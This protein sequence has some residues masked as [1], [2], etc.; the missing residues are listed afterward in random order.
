MGLHQQVII[1]A[2]SYGGIYRASELRVGM[3]DHIVDGGHDQ[4]HP[5]DDDAENNGADADEW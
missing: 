5:R 2:V 1:N 4:H 3:I